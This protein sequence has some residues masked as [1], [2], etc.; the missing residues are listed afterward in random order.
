MHT[1]KFLTAMHLNYNQICIMNQKELVGT[2]D[3][4][5]CKHGQNKWKASTINTYAQS[6]VKGLSII[7]GENVKNMTLISVLLKK[8]GDTT[9]TQDVNQAPIVVLEEVEKEVIKNLSPQDA[10]K[11]K[12]L[13]HIAWMVQA[14]SVNA[15]KGLANRRITEG[16]WRVSWQQH[17]TKNR[18]GVK[19]VTIKR[20]LWT[21]FMKHVIPTLPQDKFPI[22]SENT[23]SKFHTIIEKALKGRSMSIRRS[24]IQEMYDKGY[25]K[26]DIRQISLHVNDKMLDKYLATKKGQLKK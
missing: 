2:V 21:P 8:Y 16:G 15:L 10:R 3:S 4:Y 19:E 9:S 14:R 1:K 12:I 5:L 17:K 6:I 26:T 24:S 20:E 25:S 7:R 18:I 22:M 13:L 11:A 23:I